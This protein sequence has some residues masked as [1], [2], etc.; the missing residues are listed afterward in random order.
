MTLPI[1]GIHTQ[2][3]LVILYI[4]GVPTVN[5]ITPG[6]YI[7]ASSGHRRFG[8]GTALKSPHNIKKL[9]LD[10]FFQKGTF[11]FLMEFIQKIDADSQFYTVSP[12][13]QSICSHFLSPKCSFPLILKTWVVDTHSERSVEYIVPVKDVFFL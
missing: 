6:N 10:F 2:V 13:L 9:H 8:L 4:P 3:G 12:T 5:W 11:S 1:S 7:P